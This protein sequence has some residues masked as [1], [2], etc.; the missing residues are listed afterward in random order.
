MNETGRQQF[1]KTSTQVTRKKCLPVELLDYGKEIIIPI[2][3]VNIE[4][5]IIQTII[6]EKIW[7]IYSAFLHSLT[8]NLKK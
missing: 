6:F 8:E 3:L 2:I 5:T 4:I 1:L 7:C